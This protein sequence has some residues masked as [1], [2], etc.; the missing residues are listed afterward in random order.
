MTIRMHSSTARFI[1]R[2]NAPLHE[3][4]YITCDGEDDAGTLMH[5]EWTVLTTKEGTGGWSASGVAGGS[6]EGPELGFPWVNLGGYWGMEGLRAGGMVEDAGHGVRTVRLTDSGGRVFEDSVENGAALFLSDQPVES[7]MTIE[8]FD[9][10]DLL[11]ASDGW[12]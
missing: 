1:K 5:W 11:V 7:P 4:W 12:G 9:S 10:N 8:L 3:L 6:G 2:R